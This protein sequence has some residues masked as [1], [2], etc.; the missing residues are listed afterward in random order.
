MISAPTV[1]IIGAGASREYELPTG[2]E[3]K[4]KLKDGLN[5]Y[6]DAGYVTRGDKRLWECV[7]HL[8]PRGTN[9]VTVAGRELSASIDKFPSIDEALH[10]WKARLDIVQLGKLAIAYYILEAERGS[11]LAT[12]NG[13]VSTDK[14]RDA[15]LST[16]LSI[17]LAGIEHGNVETAF[18]NV[19]IILGT[20]TGWCFG[21]RS[22]RKRGPP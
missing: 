15:W 5:F 1:L 13:S 18:Q 17:A 2:A 4:D 10:W 19:T 20:A 7:K 12:R 22:D 9:N 16:F 11:P 14:P 3:L 6:H 8:S 21:H